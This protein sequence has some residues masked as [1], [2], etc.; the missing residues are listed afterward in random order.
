MMKIIDPVLLCPNCEVIR[1]DRSR[2]C[3]F[4]GR[5]VERFDH[6]CPWINNCVGIGNHHYFISFLLSVITLLA[7]VLTTIGRMLVIADYSSDDIQLC[8]LTV[9]EQSWY[10]STVLIACSLLI[11]VI[12]I[13]FI[14]PVL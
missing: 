10:F 5:C 12:S 13:M 2:H 14:L 11:T 1:T 7:T 3:T 4:C 8:F 6:H 9:F